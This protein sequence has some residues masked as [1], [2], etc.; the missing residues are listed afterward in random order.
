M[1]FFKQLFVYEEVVYIRHFFI[2]DTSF[3]FYLSLNGTI[4]KEK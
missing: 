2:L 1:Y 3:I 4:N